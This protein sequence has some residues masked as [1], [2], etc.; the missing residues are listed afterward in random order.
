M[1]FKAPESLAEQIALHLGRNI[2]LGK[3]QSGER[4]QELKVAKELDVSRGSVREALLILEGRHLINIIPRRGAVVAEFS[5]SQVC[6]LYDLYIH[7]LTLLG[8]KIIDIW[9]ESML[10][11][12]MDEYQAMGLIV[13]MDAP[14]LEAFINHGFNIMRKAYE[15]VGNRYLAEVLEDLQPAIHRTYYQSILNNHTEIIESYQFFSALLDA[16]L[17]R[18]KEKFENI[19]CNYGHHQRQQVLSTLIENEEDL[20]TLDAG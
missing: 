10:E 5:E 20:A 8:Q 17:E 11:P 3:I 18:D 12:L 16:V 4:I 7:L 2:I 6:E 14:D 1:T 13:K 15:I 19:I 9:Q